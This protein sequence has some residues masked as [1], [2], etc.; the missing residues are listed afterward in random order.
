MAA[1]SAIQIFD[2][3]EIAAS[4][5]ATFDIDLERMGAEGFF[6]LQI[7]LTGNGVAKGEFLLSNNNVNWIEPTGATDIFAGFEDDD[8]PGA[9]GKDLFSFEPELA[10]H[11]RIKIT[12][13]GT[14]AKFYISAWLAI[15]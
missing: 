5:N 1:I 10:K 3:E 6:S 9:D 2:T 14:S 8:G 13:T 15:Q 7:T 11:L 12:E 4:G